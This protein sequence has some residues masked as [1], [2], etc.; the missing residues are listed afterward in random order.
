MVEDGGD[1]MHANAARAREP[2]TF[3]RVRAG[4]FTAADEHVL[5]QLRQVGREL[6]DEPVPQHMLDLLRAG[7]D[8]QN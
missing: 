5:E 4:R 7:E 6:I 3:H 2:R 8:P 1:R